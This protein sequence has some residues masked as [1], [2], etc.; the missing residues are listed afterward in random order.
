MEADNLAHYNQYKFETALW[1]RGWRWMIVKIMVNITGQRMVGE[2]VGD[3]GRQ[4]TF[5]FFELI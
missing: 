4:A 1:I 2:D 3:L 5:H